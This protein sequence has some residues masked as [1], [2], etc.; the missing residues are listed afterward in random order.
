[1]YPII[2]LITTERGLKGHRRLGLAHKRSQAQ[3]ENDRAGFAGK[4]FKLRV[5][6]KESSLEE[7]NQVGS[8]PNT[9]DLGACVCA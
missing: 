8:H 1:M 7:P 6:L 4:G 9:R 3:K 5:H 2:V